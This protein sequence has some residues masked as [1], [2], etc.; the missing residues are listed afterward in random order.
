MASDDEPVEDLTAPTSS[1]VST[2]LI[3]RRATRRAVLAGGVAAAGVAG[4]YAAMGDRLKL[5][6]ED[7]PELEAVRSDTS[8]INKESVK[9]NH[10]LRRAGFG[11]TKEEHDHYQ[12]LGLKATIEEL[13]AYNAVDDSEAEKAAAVA[14]DTS[15]GQRVVPVSG[16]LTRMATTKRPLQEKMTLFWHGLL[17]SQLSVVRDPGAMLTQIDFYREHA[18]DRFPDILKGVSKDPAMMIYLNVDNSFRGA[19]NENYARELMELFA[20]GVGNFSETDV[21]EAAR[22]FTGWQIPRER[23]PNPG[24]LDIKEP[25]FRPQRFDSS[26]KTFFGKTGN[27]GPDDIVDIVVEQPA[28]AKYIVKRLFSFFVYPDPSDDDLKPFIEAYMNNGK[29]IRSV[30][31]AMFKSDVFYS[32]KA[33]RAIVKSPVEFAVGAIKAVN[34]QQR[35]PELTVGGGQPR[36]GGVVGLMGQT[37][38]EPPNVAGWPGNASWLNASTMFARLNFVNGITGGGPQQRP[39]PNAP[40]NAAPASTAAAPSGF[41]TG[42]TAQALAHFLPLVLDDNVSPETRQVLLD[43]AGGPDVQLTPEQLRGVVY[44]ILGSPQFHLS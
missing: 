37:L 23:G 18:L 5:F 4:A 9:I 20:L 7:G 39:R 29:S 43:Y 11:M 35:V 36:L 22:A 31:E 6:G 24:Q 28:S 42:T 26:P 16:W 30:V 25:V 34:G 44:L 2:A 12:Q 38:Y 14:N 19:P 8:A 21:R 33:Y 41:E 32:P 1:G 10:L 15:N 13:L 27:F 3:R 40:A 17:T